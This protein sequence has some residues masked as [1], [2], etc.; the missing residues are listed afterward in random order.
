MI[1]LG[2]FDWK[3]FFNYLLPPDSVTWWAILTTVGV[4][5]AAQVFGVIFGVISALMQ[6][7]KSRVLRFLAGA[8]VWF[9]R[10]TPVIIQI[11]FMFYGA[12]LFLGFDPFPPERHVLFLTL[13]GAVMA[14]TAALAINEGAYMSEIV[15]AGIAAV[16]KGQM[17]AALTVGMTRGQG[18][19]RIVLP[20]AGRVIM[21][22]LG[23]EFN[24]MLKTTA[25]LNF[26]GVT[27]IFFDA[28]TRISS[29]FK[30]PE[31]L[32][33]AA[34]LYLILTTLWGF[35]QKRIENKFNESDRDHVIDSPSFR[36]RMFGGPKP[37]LADETT[38][39][40]GG[41]E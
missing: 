22:P 5:V 9:F 25:L 16:D 33:G 10:G 38:M 27:E 40:I 35:V 23:N 8:Y 34:V 19:R 11:F 1:A 17:E 2:S 32:A 31:Y 24:N 28:E 3:A 15:R 29:T 4:A 37:T 41:H 20:Q 26:I 36:S 14:G 7:S 6:L 30:Y 18:M 12:A 39:A 21:P 13:P